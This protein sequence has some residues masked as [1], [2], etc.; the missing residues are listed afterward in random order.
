MMRTYL[1]DYFPEV[2]TTSVIKG[3]HYVFGGM[4]LYMHGISKSYGMPPGFRSG[5]WRFI[6]ILCMDV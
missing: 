2:E 3:Y 4:V 5:Q 6:T 1:G